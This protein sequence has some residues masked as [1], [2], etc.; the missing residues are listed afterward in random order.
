MAA[1]KGAAAG[2]YFDIGRA[3]SGRDALGTMSRRTLRLLDAYLAVEPCEVGAILRNRSGAVYSRFTMP[4]DFR[5]VSESLF[6]GDKRTL[7]DMRRSGA[8]EAL[9]GGAEPGTVS[10]KM[11]YDRHVQRPACSLSARRSCFRTFRRC[12]PP[13]RPQAYPRERKGMKSWN[14]LPERVGTQK[15]ARR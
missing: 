5:A 4:D 9:A 6:P 15:P 14:S 13:P 11:A 7:A 12:R 10:A 2:R 1:M 8:I 3:K